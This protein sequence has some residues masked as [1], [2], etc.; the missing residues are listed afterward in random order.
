MEIKDIEKLC[1]APVSTAI[2][3]LAKA[4]AIGTD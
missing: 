4:F 3:Q 2:S 1:D